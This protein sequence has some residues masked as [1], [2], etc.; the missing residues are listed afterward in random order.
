MCIRDSDQGA[1]RTGGGAAPQLAVPG[2]AAEQEHRGPVAVVGLAAH[3]RTAVGDVHGARQVGEPVGGDGVVEPGV[4]RAQQGVVDPVGPG[5]LGGLAQGGGDV[6]VG[7]QAQQSRLVVHGPVAGGVHGVGGLH[8]AAGTGGV[9]LDGVRGL[10]DRGEVAPDEGGVAGLAQVHRPRPAVLPRP[11]R[12]HPGDV[13]GVVLGDQRR[14]V[15]LG[16]VEVA[17]L[18]QL[19][20]DADQVVVEDGVVAVLADVEPVAVLDEVRGDVARPVGV[21]QLRVG[22]PDLGDLGQLAVP[23]RRHVRVV[24]VVAARGDELVAGGPGVALTEPVGRDHVVEGGGAPGRDGGRRVVE[25]ERPAGRRRVQD[26][27]DRVVVDHGDPRVHGDEVPTADRHLVPEVGDG[28]GAV[29]PLELRGQGGVVA[30]GVEPL[31]PR[32]VVVDPEPDRRVGPRVDVEAAVLVG[33][34]AVVVALPADRGAVVL[35]D[36]RPRRRGVPD[37]GAAGHDQGRGEDRG[38]PAAALSTV[39]LHVGHPSDHALARQGPK[40]AM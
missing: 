35:R 19:D 7:E 6:P 12:V 18:Q 39:P 2:P 38:R 4:D 28:D 32:G 30:A 25:R 36:G 21:A 26:V 17:G 31:E 27:R 34:D 20:Q 29:V 8:D 10:P 15:V 40:D 9:G 14:Q 1:H 33:Q 3:V 37:L 23:V 16:A 24:G 22:H 5:R 13:T 11:V